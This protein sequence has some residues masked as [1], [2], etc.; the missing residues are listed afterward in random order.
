MEEREG[1]GWRE[2]EKGTRTYKCH[3]GHE[4]TFRA[5]GCIEQT[6]ASQ[7]ILVQELLGCKKGKE[8]R[9]N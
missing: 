1:K 6:D 3:I 4:D 8:T 2:S 9:A 5:I 7:M